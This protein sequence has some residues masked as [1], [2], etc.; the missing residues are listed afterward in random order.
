[1]TAKQYDPHGT[2]KPVEYNKMIDDLVEAGNV[3]AIALSWK[4]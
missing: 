1:M 3:P 2:I 4:S